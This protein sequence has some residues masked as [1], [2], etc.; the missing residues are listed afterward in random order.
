[1]KKYNIQNYVRYKE[2]LAASMPDEK[3]W[4]EYS[5]DELIIKFMPLVENLARKFSTSQQA[6]GVLTIN[7]LIQEGN[8]GLVRAIDKLNWDTLNDSEDIERTI[9]SFLSKRI[10]GSIRRA[11]DINR[12]DVKIP[13]HKLNQ[14]RKNPDD[15]K[16]VSLFFN[17]IFS[18]Y[19]DHTEEDE[20]S[21][22]NIAD[23]SKKYNID[24][25]NTYLLGL[26]KE[27]LNFQQYE[28]LR[29]FYGLD[30]KKNT[31]KEIAFKLRI[32]VPTANVRI[33]QIKKEAID[34]LIANVDPNQV[35]D[36]L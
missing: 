11:I 10:K 15:D 33:S 12:G 18:S 16:M 31:A 17:S 29:L 28:V 34:K 25:L 26:M 7:D 23:D 8:Y 1:M 3:M 6:S 32:E 30:C 13:E 22:F 14:I 21:I 35:I 24:L 4:D 19:D 5:R 36:Y 27:Y 2:D 20:S 9:K